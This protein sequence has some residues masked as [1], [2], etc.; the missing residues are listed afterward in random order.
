MN[1]KFVF[2]EGQL[3]L[4]FGQNGY[5]GIVVCGVG[6][7]DISIYESGWVYR[8]LSKNISK[9]FS[10]TPHAYMEINARGH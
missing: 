5:F 1:V 4:G 9:P 8:P 2:W 3:V 6:G 7:W 10:R